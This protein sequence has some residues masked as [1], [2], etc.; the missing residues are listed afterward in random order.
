MFSKKFWVHT[1]ERAAKTAGQVFVAALGYSGA[2]YQHI[3]WKFI[4]IMVGVSSA[5]SVASSLAS[6]PL[7][8]DKGGPS[9]V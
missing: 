7:G 9:A 6:L 3:D 2:A 1:A 4:A 5:L 8:S